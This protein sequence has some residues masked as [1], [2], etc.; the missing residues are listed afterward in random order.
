MKICI[1]LA[2]AVGMAL[3][4]LYLAYLLTWKSLTKFG[5]ENA[6]LEYTGAAFMKN[7]YC[8]IHQD[9]VASSKEKDSGVIPLFGGISSPDCHSNAPPVRGCIMLVRGAW[10]EQLHTFGKKKDCYPRR[11]FRFIG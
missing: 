5:Y 4:L 9:V 6:V 3:M 7:R 10:A 8:I 1:I 11:P 2:F